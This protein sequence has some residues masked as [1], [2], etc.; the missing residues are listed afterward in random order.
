M[1]GQ[2]TS[3]GLSVNYLVNPNSCPWTFPGLF[4]CVVR[5]FFFA[6][7]LNDAFDN[8]LEVGVVVGTLISNI[9]VVLLACAAITSIFEWYETHER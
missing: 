4:L 5:L 2:P 6:I 8:T 9:P 1:L 3:G 7:V